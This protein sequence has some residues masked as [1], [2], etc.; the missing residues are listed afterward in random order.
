MPPNR[1]KPI[2]PPPVTL[3]RCRTCV[4]RFLSR[5]LS[6]YNRLRILQPAHGAGLLVSAEWVWLALILER[7]VFLSPHDS[8][9]SFEVDDLIRSHI[10][11]SRHEPAWP[12]NF[13]QIDLLSV[14]IAK[15][16]MKTACRH[17]ATAPNFVHLNMAPGYCPHAHADGTAI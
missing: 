13:Q 6:R 2:V 11:H 1:V 16:R 8:G 4:K 14:A 9:T 17:H 15:V 12:V 5:F 3:G 7:S 10:F